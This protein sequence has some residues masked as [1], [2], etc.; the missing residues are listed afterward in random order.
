M[1][2]E[3]N[4]GRWIKKM[5]SDLTGVVSVSEVIP[6]ISIYEIVDSLSP[7]VPPRS[8]AYHLI[9]IGVGHSYAESLT[10][11]FARLAKEHKVTPRILF[12]HREINSDEERNRRISGLVDTAAAKATSQINGPG[13]TAEK[14]IVMV[15]GLTLQKRLRFLTFLTWRPVFNKSMC[16]P[17]RAWCPSCLED[18]R[19]VSPLIYEQ[20]C[21]THRNVKVCSTHGIRLETK[22]PH[23]QAS[24]WVL[25]G[26][27]RPG[28]CRRCNR[29]LG[30]HLSRNGS[31]FEEIN[32]DKADY[33]MFSARQIG[34]LIKVAPFLSFMP[35]LEVSKGSISKCA[36]KY[37]DGNLSSFVR[38]FGQDRSVLDSLWKGKNRAAPLELLLRIGFRTGISLLDLL[39]KEDTLDG[40]NPLSTS[41]SLSKRLSPKLKRETVLK[42]L[43]AAVEETPPPS[44]NE[45]A[46]RLGYKSTGRLRTVNAQLCDQIVVNFNQ[47]ASEYIRRPFKAR[48]QDLEVIKSALESALKENSP[49][50]LAEIARQ[51]G[52]K[53]SQAFRKNFPLLCKA[54]AKRRR[55]LVSHRREQIKVELEQALTSDPPTSLDAIAKKLSYKTKAVLRTEYPKLCR[56]VGDRYAKYKQA[57][58]MLRVEN[59]VKSILAESPPPTATVAF[60]RLGV[61]DAFLRTHF[62]KE[63]RLISA[64]YLEY[65]KAQA[66]RNKEMDRSKIRDTIQDLIKRNIFPSMNAVMNVYTVKYLR[67]SEFWSTILQVRREF[68]FR[69]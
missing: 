19:L 6:G 45:V 27:F 52:Y 68:G 8:W 56:K 11:Y 60:S 44:L 63:H 23:C 10:S 65:R 41:T 47:H 12:N 21:W 69:V 35:D 40:F 32:S 4:V 31:I 15:E 58:L 33:E 66:E 14:W 48:I 62:P 29:W 49:P 39:T 43:L 26:S 16:R 20:L 34:E 30:H 17:E 5:P 18:M 13:L 54:L 2:V 22:C 53:S 25:Y 57:Q 36:E 61:S 50:S 67:R 59:E 28:L 9:P 42:V 7:E 38:F 55:E 46:E 1:T 24:S 64:R 3:A 51:L 37:F